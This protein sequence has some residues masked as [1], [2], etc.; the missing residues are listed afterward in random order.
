MDSLALNASLDDLSNLFEFGDIDLNNLSTVDTSQY[1]EHMQHAGTHPSTPYDELSEAQ[2]ISGTNAQ[3]FGGHPQYGM[4]QNAAQSHHS[5]R[6]NAS[7]QFPAD[8]SFR[9]AMQQG[10]HPNQQYQLQ[11]MPSYPMNQHIPPTPN[12]YEM[13]GEAGRFL[14]SQLDPQQRAVLEQRYQLRKEEA[15][16]SNVRT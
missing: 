9:P 1:D 13:H 7:G 5:Q 12:S 10:Y 3:D 14:Q 16:R 4:P 6:Y 2:A 8:S 11:G 15:V